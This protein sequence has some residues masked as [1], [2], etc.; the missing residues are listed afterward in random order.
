[1]QP[2]LGVRSNH[3]TAQRR[4]AKGARTTAESSSAALSLRAGKHADNTGG[5]I[6]SH[7]AA[8]FSGLSVIEAICAYG[9]RDVLKCANFRLSPNPHFKYPPKYLLSY[10]A[11]KLKGSPSRVLREEFPHLKEWCG[12]HLRAPSCFHGSVGN[13]WDVVEKYISACNTYEYNRE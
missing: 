6:H 11:K 12:E 9:V 2:C 1:M 5:G 7:P 3:S 8:E 4:C 13:G 10:I